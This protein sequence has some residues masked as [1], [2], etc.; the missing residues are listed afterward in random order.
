MQLDYN[1][2]WREYFKL[3]E[4]SPS[5][6]VRTRSWRGNKIK[7]ISAGFRG[8]QKNGKAV[9]WYVGFKNKV[10]L[11]HRI[12]WVMTYGSIDPNLVIDHLDGNPLNNQIV[13]LSLKTQANN[14]RNKS[15]QT[16]N[17]SGITGVMLTNNGKGRIYFTA[18]WNEID[19]SFN[20]K[21]FSVAKLGEETAKT[22]AIAYREQQVQRLISEGA[23]YTER[24]G[25]T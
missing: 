4:S 11:I 20:R 23:N 8:I 16:S 5:M 7:E 13:N 25:T 12:I 19:G 22:L 15:K 3:D 14:A 24:H 10:Y 6:L 9:G 2:N 17:T 18:H 1:L 21:H